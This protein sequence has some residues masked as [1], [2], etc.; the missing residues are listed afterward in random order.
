MACNVPDR[1]PSQTAYEWVP[2]HSMSSWCTY[3]T[4]VIDLTEDNDQQPEAP[5]RGGSI[6]EAIVIDSDEETIVIESDEEPIDSD[7]EAIEEEESRPPDA[8]SYSGEQ[9]ESSHGVYDHRE[10][11]T[12]TKAASDVRDPAADSTVKAFDAREDIFSGSRKT[13]R[14]V[15]GHFLDDPKL[16]D[17]F[18]A[19]SS[20]EHLSKRRRPC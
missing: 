5:T 18:P 20:P 16:T 13:S 14:E 8:H 10:I 2:E 4:N 7:E 15:S 17:F 12:T 9:E 1:V 3:E 6:E 19:V 11:C